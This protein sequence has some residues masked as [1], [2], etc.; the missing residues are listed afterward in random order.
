VK[1]FVTSGRVEGGALR[2]RNLSALNRLLA[3]TR[4][5]DVTITIERAHATRS[6]DQNALYWA[7]YVEPLAE[8]TGYTVL[9]M[10]E[11]L[12]QRFLPKK[13]LFIQD[14]DGQIVDEAD[15]PQPTTTTLNKIEFGDYLR[16]I[17]AFALGLGVVV[18]T[19]REA[20]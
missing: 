10:H 15:L 19:N 6:L 13:H 2:L 3:Q 5:C 11:Y 16:E 8:H 18:G 1:P 14:A 7:G 17:E 9:E 20:A 12:K 4:D